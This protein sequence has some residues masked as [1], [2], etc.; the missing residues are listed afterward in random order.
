M[1]TNRPAQKH[2][3]GRTDFL[4]FTT[5][6]T[7]VPR[8][9]GIDLARQI[10]DIAAEHQAEDI[11]LLDIRPVAFFAHYFVIMTGT[12]D[13]HIEALLRAI[14]EKLRNEE[15]IRPLQVEGSPSSG[16]VL[17][18]YGDVIVHILSPEQRAFYNLEKL[19]AEAPIVVR[20]Q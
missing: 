3:E 4:Q 20:M 17:I 18:D 6:P 10:V 13:R 7:E 11:I 8:L 1:Q 12:S 2:D 16:W 14:T 9:E 15:H 5:P 19:W